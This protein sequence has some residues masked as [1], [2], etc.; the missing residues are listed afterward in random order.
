MTKRIT[1]T[2]DQ[3]SIIE[4]SL[5]ASLKYADSEYIS[6]VDAILKEIKNNRG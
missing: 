3:L 4:S 5:E 6:E 2:K 1:F